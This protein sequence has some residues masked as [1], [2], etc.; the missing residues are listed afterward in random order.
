[1]QKVTLKAEARSA[2]GKGTAR[3]LRRS[4]SI[5]AVIYKSGKAEALT[6][7]HKEM[8]TFINKTRGEK[9]LIT[10]DFGGNQR[11][12]LMKEYQV[13]PVDNTLLHADFMEIALDETVRVPIRI[14]LIGEAIGVKR[15]K[16][17]LERQL[18]EV[19]VEALANN[20]PGH[21]ELDITELAAGSTLHVSDIVIPDGVKMLTDLSDPVA[22]VNM[23]KIVV[24]EEVEEEEGAE[25]AAEG[26]KAEGEAEGEG[27]KKPEEKP[28]EKKEK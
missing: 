12:A 18:R 11:L 20:I 28:E 8:I 23:P 19:E 3:G 5:P 26:E 17:I 15:D 16:G 4:G 2:T 1:M 7:D 9:V 6:L 21:L 22:S 14:K 13:D 27:E 25:E 24:E 10:M